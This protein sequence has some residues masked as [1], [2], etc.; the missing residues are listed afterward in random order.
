MPGGWSP[1][2]SL[3]RLSIVVLPASTEYSLWELARRNGTIE[4]EIFF[5]AQGVVYDVTT[6]DAF[7]PDGAY[8]ENWAG[9]DATLA[10][11]IMSLDKKDVNRQDWDALTEKQQKTLSD[12]IAYF[13]VKYG[14]AGQCSLCHWCT[15][16]IRRF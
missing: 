16:R 4:P 12:W 10:L 14:R 1:R 11:G 9:R 13:D 8:G 3:I 2:E 15:S 5:S 7:Q 6:A